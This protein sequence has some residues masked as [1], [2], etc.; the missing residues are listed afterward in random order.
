M[1]F[2]DR[3]GRERGS[4]PGQTYRRGTRR[5]GLSTLNFSQKISKLF[6]SK[7]YMYGSK[8]SSFNTFFFNLWNMNYD[9]EATGIKSINYKSP[10]SARIYPCLCLVVFKQNQMFSLQPN[11]Q[12]TE[13]TQTEYQTL[14][15]PSLSKHGREEYFTSTTDQ[16]CRSL[17]LHSSMPITTKTR[18]NIQCP[19]T[20]HPAGVHQ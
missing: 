20:Q 18:G 10:T 5:H 4:D 3:A 9:A 1:Q 15:I 8:L 6:F 16:P 17:Q 11:I 12:S 19:T 14:K 7:N 2:W 13:Q